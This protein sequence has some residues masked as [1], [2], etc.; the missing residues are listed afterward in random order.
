MQPNTRKQIGD[1]INSVLDD[2]GKPI[3]AWTDDDILIQTMGLDSLD[4]AVLVVTL[5]S[6]LGTDPFRSGRSAVRPLGELTEIYEE[7]LRVQA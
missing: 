1:A 6:V 5:E 2:K 3:R 7:S 4:L